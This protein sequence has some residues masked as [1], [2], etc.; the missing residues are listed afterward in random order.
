VKQKC[1]EKKEREHMIPV[2]PIGSHPLSLS[3]YLHCVSPFVSYAFTLQIEAK[4]LLRMLVF[5]YQT[6]QLHIA[7]YRFLIVLFFFFFHNPD[8]VDGFSLLSLL[9]FYTFFIN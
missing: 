7:E 9:C 8:C 4:G 2:A 3:L 5:F 1:L 6:I